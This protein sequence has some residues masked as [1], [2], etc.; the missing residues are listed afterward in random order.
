MEK[1]KPIKRDK[2]IQPLSREHHHSLLLCWKIRKGFAK[3]VAPERMKVYTDWFFEN[4]ILPH[5]EIEEKYMFPVLGNEHELVKKAL[6]EHRRLKRLFQ[7]EE[8]IEK[9]LSLIEEELD[10][11]IRFEER[12]LFNIIQQEAT[13][14]ELAMIAEKHG[15]EEKFQENTADE[16]W[17]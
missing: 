1:S 11:H 5:F 8:E 6:S 15:P 7:N 9:S 2:L 16:F 17:V 3:G 14:E 10:M 12:E 4:H 13:P